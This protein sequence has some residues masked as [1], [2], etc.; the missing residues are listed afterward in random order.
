MM[1]RR[2]IRKKTTL[3]AKRFDVKLL[4]KSGPEAAFLQLN[5]QFKLEYESE[6]FKKATLTVEWTITEDAL[7]RMDH[8]CPEYLVRRIQHVNVNI[9][10]RQFRKT[11]ALLDP[12]SYMSQYY[13]LPALCNL[14][15]ILTLNFSI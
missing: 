12:K 3:P 11:R 15:K 6:I 4:I 8:P 13:W 7:S 14:S 10:S 5:K 2:M 1:Y 9:I